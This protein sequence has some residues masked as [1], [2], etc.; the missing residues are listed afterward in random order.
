MK[1]NSL[2]AKN[3]INSLYAMIA[4]SVLMITFTF[5]TIYLL[6]NMSLMFDTEADLNSYLVLAGIANLIYSGIYITCWVLFIMWF[7]RAYFNLHKL[8]PSSQ[9]RYSEG[10]AAGSWFIPVFYLWGPYQIATN[11]FSKSEDLLVEHDLMDRQPKYHQTKRWWWGL[12]ISAGIIQRIGAKMDGDVDIA[13]AGSVLGIIASV[14]LIGA[15]LLAIQTIKNYSKMEELLKQIPQTDGA[16]LTMQ[17]TNDDLL[18]S[19]I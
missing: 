10:W 19:G 1:P 5:Y 17:I 6:N 16:T 7:R 13:I 15:G 9:L 11:L 2:R 8:V 14:L 4:V 18:D 12:W 3:A